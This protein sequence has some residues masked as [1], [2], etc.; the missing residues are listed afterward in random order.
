MET[1]SLYSPQPP[2]VII[3]NGIAG[4]TAAEVL[5]AEDPGAAI[6][7]IADDPAP[8]YYRPALKDFLAGRISEEMLWARPRN[9]YREQQM[10]FIPGRVTTIHPLR[11]FVQLHNGQQVNYKK[12]LLATGAQ[13]NRLTCPGVQLAGVSTLRSMTDYKEV[14]RQL[15]QNARILVYGGG[16]LA[17]ET[18]ETLAH[19]GYQV[20]HMLRS[21]TLWSEVLDATASDLIMQEEWHSGIEVRKNEEIQEIV[22]DNGHVTHVVTAGGEEI[23]CDMVL[24]AIGIEPNLNFIKAGGILCGRGVKTDQNQRTSVVDVYAAG[25]VTETNIPGN[26]KVRLLGQWYPAIGQARTAAYHMLGKQDRILP[27]QPSTF[28]NATF[29]HGLDFAAIG[30]TTRLPHPLYAQEIIAEPQPR[31]YRK[32]LLQDGVPI[33]ALFLG[34][35]K[36]ALAFK[37]AIDA[38]VSLKPVIK[39][40]FADDFDLDNWLDEQQVPEVQISV[41]AEE[42]PGQRIPNLEIT[43]EPEYAE[44]TALGFLMPVPHPKVRVALRETLVKQ[45][46]RW[47]RIGREAGVDIRVEHST[48]SRRHAEIRYEQG[49]YK[50]R[51][52]GSANGTFI[53]N[54]LLSP[55]SPRTLRN[56]DLLR[57]GDVQFRLQL[58]PQ[59]QNTGKLASEPTGMLHLDGSQLHANATRIIPESVLAALPGSPSLVIVTQDKQP[60]IVSLD[61]DQQYSIGRDKKNTI[62]LDDRATSRRHA[63]IFSAPDGFYIRDLES[64]YG[65]FI[66]NHKIQNAYHLEHGDRIVIGNTLIY[67]SF[68]Y[69]L[70]A[71]ESTRR[72]TETRIPVVSK[73]TSTQP[74]PI[75]FAHRENTQPFN[76]RR[77]GFEIDMCIGCNRCMD[78]CPIPMSSLI[79]I[80]DLNNATISDKA[81]ARVER[82]T[83]E[84]IL[85]GSC[86]PVCPVDN[87]RDLLMLSLKQRIGALWDQPIDPQQIADSLPPDWDTDQ[88]IKRLREQPLF[89]DSQ[90]VPENYLL[91]L[92]ASSQL[93]SLEPGVTL[94]REGEYG[95]DMYFILDG[96]LS[97][98]TREIGE[99]ALPIAVLG[100]GEYVGEYG[101]LT[102]QPYTTTTSTQT[103]TLILQVAEQVMQRFMQLVPRARNFFERMG[104]ARFIEGILKRMSLFQ[105]ISDAD[106]RMLVEQTQVKPYNRNERLF[107]E[108]GRDGGTR[109]ARETFHILLEGFVKVGRLTQAGTG[110]NKSNERII[111]YRQGGDYFVG[112]LDLLGDGRAVTVTAMMRTRVAEIPRSAI[113]ALFTRYPEVKQRFTLRL[114]EYITSTANARSMV[115]DEANMQELA[116][117]TQPEQPGQL[118]KPAQSAPEVRAGLHTIVDT[119]IVEGTE[120]LVIDLDKCIHC[121]ECEDACARRYGHSRMN[122]KG[123]IVGNISI[124]T[125]CRQ[126]QDPVCM[127]CSRAGIARMPNGEVYITDSC[128]GCGICAERCPYGAISIVNVEDETANEPVAAARFNSIFSKTKEKKRERKALP[129]AS[130]SVTSGPLNLA[131]LDGYDELRKKVAI[132]CDL[133]AGYKDQ[134]CVEACPTGAA[135]RVQPVKFF[136]STEEILRKRTV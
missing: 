51:D 114:N 39:R 102:G 71:Q 7:I 135:I 6:T 128:I 20:I 106:I 133:C 34:N 63:E 54:L 98:G 101:M 46:E 117:L 18:A 28:Y 99:Q 26:G 86:V 73:E 36:Q 45:E 12:L 111:A 70:P 67:C 38:H 14:M 91:H 19:R 84:C 82:F 130:R 118:E 30:E 122:R 112:G 72:L 8:V 9:F 3:G 48:V 17:L 94:F 33:G 37:R 41:L 52:S 108:G 66:N 109:P 11:H 57:F 85:C 96:R 22:G 80:A 44:G 61:P 123:M 107:T 60:G 27:L 104:N 64:S 83:H 90:L 74:L 43:T 65:V 121:N 132:K 1:R 59:L 10:Q 62:M 77:V 25:D 110:R 136:G 55:N 78:A 93:I 129:M 24:I 116:Q 68:P 95:R 119:G 120:V 53:N 40:I 125:T 97:V 15:E 127:L 69:M 29:L 87:H 105:G 81:S 49:E 103:P 35:R 42:I 47:Q 113:L 92:V 100:R 56:N 79:Q 134:A 16:T 32:V 89:S 75:E 124:A 131:P 21:D 76:E 50:L 23:R 115:F 126:C 88:L 58:R 2:Y 31:S 4:I 13:A 5:R